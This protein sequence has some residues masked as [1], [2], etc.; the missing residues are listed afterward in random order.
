MYALARLATKRPV[1]ITVLAAA[2][3]V[4]GWT[5]WQSLPLDLFPDIQSPTILVAVRSGDRPPTEMERLYGEP[6]AD[7][8]GSG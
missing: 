6:W 2:I 1:A 8:Q 5:A 3:V 4:L 7:W